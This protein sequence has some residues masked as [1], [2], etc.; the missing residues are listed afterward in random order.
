[1]LSK[2]LNAI[3]DFVFTPKSDEP[4]SWQEEYQDAKLDD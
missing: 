3:K 1:M 4:K 2:I